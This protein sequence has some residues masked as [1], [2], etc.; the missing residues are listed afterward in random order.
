MLSGKSF[1]FP[2]NISFYPLLSGKQALFPD[3]KAEVD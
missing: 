1:D 3:E 2:D